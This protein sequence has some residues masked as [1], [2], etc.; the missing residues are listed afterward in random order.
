[1]TEQEHKL[2]LTELECKVVNV[3]LLVLAGVI[4]AEVGDDFEPL[5]Y[6]WSREAIRLALIISK[7]L[8]CD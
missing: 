8:K 4:N 2:Y 7:R 1:M 3:D 5:K 6:Y